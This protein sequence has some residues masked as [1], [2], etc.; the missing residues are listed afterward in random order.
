[1]EIVWGGKE[2]LTLPN[3]EERKF[4][5][6]GDSVLLQGFAKGNGY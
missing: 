1:M 2:P 4:L 3:G 6:D 5:S